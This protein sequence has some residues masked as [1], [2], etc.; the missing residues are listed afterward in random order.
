MLKKLLLVLFLLYVTP[1]QAEENS[2]ELHVGLGKLVFSMA[3]CTLPESDKTTHCA[4]ADK[5]VILVELFSQDADVP[6]WSGSFTAC[7]VSAV[8]EIYDHNVEGH[9]SDIY[10]FAWGCIPAILTN[11]GMNDIIDHYDKQKQTPTLNF[12][13]Y[14]GT[15]SLGVSYAW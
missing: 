11:W 12:Y 15:P 6:E 5:I 13:N 1:S 8:K 4:L 2:N 7:S 14:N 9:V 10:D 3:V